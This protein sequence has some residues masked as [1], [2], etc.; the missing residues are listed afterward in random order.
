M[1]MNT[2]S[3]LSLVSILSLSIMG[4][5]QRG[6]VYEQDQYDREL[7]ERNSFY[8][9]GMQLN[10]GLNKIEVHKLHDGKC[11]PVGIFSKPTPPDL[12]KYDHYHY[13]LLS[14]DGVLR[15]E[16]DPNCGSATSEDIAE[17]GFY[18]VTSF[19]ANEWNRKWRAQTADIADIDFSIEAAEEVPE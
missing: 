5:F 17:T 12:C 13:P 16:N 4:C 3:R 9:G 1:N 19:M 11:Y 15:G 10:S 6:V 7:A 8:C 18:Y 2:L 14:L